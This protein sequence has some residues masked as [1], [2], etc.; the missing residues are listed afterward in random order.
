[1]WDE[2][3]AAAEV[4]RRGTVSAAAD[5]LGVH[6]ATINRRIDTLEARIGGKLFQRHKQGYT[7]TELGHHLL[8][9]ADDTGDQLQG[10]RRRAL[11]QGE[12]L[13]GNLIVTSTEALAPTILARIA[14]FT[15]IHDDVT[16]TFRVSHSLFRLEFGE[17]HVAFRVGSRPEEPD[18]VVLPYQPVRVGLY[19]SQEYLEQHGRPDR[20]NLSAHRFV[21]LKVNPEFDCLETWLEELIEQPSIALVGDKGGVVTDAIRAGVGIGFVPISVAA[22]YPSLVELMPPDPAWQVS[23]W[24]VTHVDLHRSPK[25]QAFIKHC[26][27]DAS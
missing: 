19:A 15:A 16:I 2:V 23:G 11:S 21:L 6:R 20:S 5:A 13:S 24:I 9:I 12:A 27:I 1:M 17:A 14:E 22:E 25:V 8:R 18:Y 7:P 3:Q 26:R 10:L 4:V